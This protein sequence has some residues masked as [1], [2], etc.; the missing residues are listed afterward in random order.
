MVVACRHTLILLLR[1]GKKQY[2][3][4]S[5]RKIL[6]NGRGLDEKTEILHD[7]RSDKC[8][9]TLHLDDGKHIG[10]YTKHSSTWRAYVDN[11][12]HGGRGI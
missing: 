7:T 3:F 2:F 9:T 11:K 6:C 5:T 1:W 4:A 8:D 10:D 12:P